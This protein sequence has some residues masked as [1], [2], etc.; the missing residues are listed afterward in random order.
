QRRLPCLVDDPH[1]PAA[2]LLQDVITGEALWSGR[3]GMPQAPD[4][5]RTG[6]SFTGNRPGQPAGREGPVYLELEAELLGQLREALQVFVELR[7]GPFFFAQQDLVVD[8]I[9]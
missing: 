6:F 1:P 7:G 5:G 8:Q 9:E 3:A 2:Q 4:P